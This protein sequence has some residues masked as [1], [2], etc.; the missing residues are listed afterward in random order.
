MAR[1]LS[2]KNC[3]K[4]SSPDSAG[5]NWNPLGLRNGKPMYACDCGHGIFVGIFG[6]AYASPADV[7]D[8]KNRMRSTG[9]DPNEKLP[10][11]G[12]IKKAM[13]EAPPGDTDFTIGERIINPIGNTGTVKDIVKEDGTLYLKVLYDKGYGDSIVTVDPQRGKIRKMTRP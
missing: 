8:Q 7:E 6:S 13:K 10:T 5:S 3:G 1:I 2:C 11:P 12:D 4:R 9:L